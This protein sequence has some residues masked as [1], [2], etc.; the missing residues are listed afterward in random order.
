MV[1]VKHKYKAALIG[2]GGIIIALTHDQ[3]LERNWISENA[4][5]AHS[6]VGQAASSPDSTP[7]FVLAMNTQ[8]K[9]S[10]GWIQKPARSGQQAQDAEIQQREPR[11]N[12]YIASR[13]REHQTGI[14]LEAAREA[15]VVS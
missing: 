4:P 1:K 6:K 7:F 9:Y 3:K 2:L 5:A 15:K 8:N 13:Q 12:W 10:T 14:L 11:R